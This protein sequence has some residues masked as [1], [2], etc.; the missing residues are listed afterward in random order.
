[1]IERLEFRAMGCGMSASLDG[2]APLPALQRRLQNVPVWFEEWEASLSRFRPESELSELNRSAGQAVPVSKTLWDVFVAARTACEETGG[3]VNP[4]VLPSMQAAG[5]DRSFTELNLNAS[6]A[7]AVIAPPAPLGL[8]EAVQANPLVQTLTLSA[9]TGLDF[10]GIAKGWAAWQTAERL[11]PFGAALVDAGGDLAI[12]GL[13]PGGE[14]WEIG[15]MNPLQPENDLLY[16]AL[17]RCGVATSGRDYRRWQAGGRMQHH[18]IDPRTGLPAE[19]DVLAATVVAPDTATAEAAAKTVLI[20]GSRDGLK[21]LEQRPGLAGL[22][23]FEDGRWMGS[24]RME[25]YIWN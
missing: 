20:L 4:A 21:W 6:Q 22:V 12:S 9:G 14:L 18:I 10:G 2:K 1:M 17:G 19:T 24:A 25:K 23:V 5:Y 13:R 16:L 11:R 15:V 8:S 3:L 7:M